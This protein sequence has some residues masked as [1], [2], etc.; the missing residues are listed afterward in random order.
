MSS[1][2]FLVRFSIV[3]LSLADFS[4]TNP[5]QA[6]SGPNKDL[7]LP[8]CRRLSSSSSSSILTSREIEAHQSTVRAQ[9]PEIVLSFFYCPDFL[10]PEAALART[11]YASLRAIST[12]AGSQ[13][14]NALLGRS[15][16]SEEE[17]GIN[18]MI[19]FSASSVGGSVSVG[20]VADVLMF[21]RRWMVRGQ[22]YGAVAFAVYVE[23]R[24]VSTGLVSPRVDPV[25]LPSSSK[26]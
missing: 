7:T 3:F 9:D 14:Y 4:R 18:C 17:R 5:T 15:F 24:K 10:V 25:L 1:W 8:Q 26:Q 13:G 12:R 16:A 23:Q 6:P 22:N 11:L 20:A 19:T 2:A 21:L